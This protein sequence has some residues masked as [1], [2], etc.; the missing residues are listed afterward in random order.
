VDMFITASVVYIDTQRGGLTSA[1]AGHCPITFF[2]PGTEKFVSTQSGFPLGIDA[3]TVY[4]QTVNALPEGAA[5]LLHT[6]GLNEARNGN[7]EFLG[8]DDLRHYFIESVTQTRDAKGAKEL[9]LRRLAE[10]RGP[11]PLADD[12]TLILIRHIA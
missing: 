12:Q 4:R 6:D 3:Q 2:S 8:V 10:F 1:S 5:A 7:G 9:L 11:A